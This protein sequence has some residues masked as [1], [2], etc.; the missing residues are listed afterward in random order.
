MRP[1]YTV[2]TVLVLLALVHA[3]MRRTTQEA[4]AVATEQSSLLRTNCPSAGSGCVVTPGGSLADHSPGRMEAVTPAGRISS[5]EE[6]ASRYEELAESLSDADRYLVLNLMFRDDCQPP[7]VSATVAA[8]ALRRWCERAPAEA[9]AWVTGLP[10]NRFRSVAFREVARD[11]AENDLERAAR[12]AREL[13][14]H[15][16]GDGAR[17]AVASVALIQTDPATAIS[18]LSMLDRSAARDELYVNAISQWA[19]IDA[20]RAAAFAAEY[21]DPAI[22]RALR[23]R[24]AALCRTVPLAASGP[25][26]AATR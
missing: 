13:P 18:L 3:W 20:D 15:N 19:A 9:A 7:S 1:F 17:L 2:T 23:A 12:W 6:L 21:T 26:F 14:K 24:L 10:A 8:I 11:W 5:E 16:D 22:C 25:L 4:V